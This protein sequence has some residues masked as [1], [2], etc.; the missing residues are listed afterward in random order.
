M[1]FLFPV[2]TDAPLYHLPFATVG[3][4]VVNVFIYF[5]VLFG[6]LPSDAGWV[7][8]YG[9]GLHP[10]E[11]LLSAFM[12]ADI[13]NLFGNMLFLWIFGLVVEG[14]I[15]WQ[16]FLICYCMIA[17]VE[18]AVEQALMLWNTGGSGSLGASTAIY[19]IMSMA[20]I[21]APRNNVKFI[22]GLVVMIRDFEIPVAMLAAIYI[23]LDLIVVLLAPSSMSSSWLHVGGVIVGIPL[24]IFLLKRGLV[25][26]EGWDIFSVLA[27]DEGGHK[28]RAAELE[29]KKAILKEKEEKKNASKSAEAFEQFDTYLAA[30]N[31]EAAI[32]LCSKMEQSGIPLKIDTP[33]LRQLVKGL[34]KQGLWEASA[35]YMTELIASQPDDIDELRVKLA[36][37]CVVKFERPG[38][39]LDLLSQV[40]ESE[41]PATYQTLIPKIKHKA[42]DLQAAGVVEL[43]DDS[44]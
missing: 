41:L 13:G 22:Y 33:R 32:W 5:A 7:L 19:G 17:I 40:N 29:K 14:K 39:A 27:N 18:S 25:D 6:V 3:L 9:A 38:R 44:W 30:G 28:A 15:G 1:L 31:A 20:A 37:I 2:S 34:H 36:Q 21:W 8:T 23:G 42:T 4:I 10:E 11:W 35:P 43:D 26:C 12:H 16:R 24:G